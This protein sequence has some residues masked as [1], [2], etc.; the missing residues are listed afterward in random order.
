M[1]LF[2]DVFDQLGS[3]IYE[4]LPPSPFQP[5]IETFAGNIEFLGHLNWF[6]PI[7]GVLKVMAAWLTVI[8]TYYT[9][10]VLLRWLKVLGG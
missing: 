2:S 3:V 10:S 5:L 1:E 8:V 7:G 9:W 6:F 4:I